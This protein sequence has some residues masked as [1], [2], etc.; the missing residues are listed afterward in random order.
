MLIRVRHNDPAAAA[1]NYTVYATFTPD[2]PD[3]HGNIAE[4]AT[5]VDMQTPQ[6]VTVGDDRLR[7]RYRLFQDQHSGGGARQKSAF[8]FNIGRYF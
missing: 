6:I 4:S 5:F 7:N 2:A 8:I 3:D 1:G